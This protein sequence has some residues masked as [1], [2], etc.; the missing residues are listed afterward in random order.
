MQKQFSI[1]IVAIFVLM[2]FG[3]LPM[4]AQI[5]NVEEKRL[6]NK[7][8][9]MGSIDIEFNFTK[10]KREVIELENN[11]QL[12]YKSGRHLFL[13]LNEN[14]VIKDGDN[15]VLNNG[16][17]HLRYNY[18]LT[19]FVTAEVFSQYQFNQVQE[20][21]KRILVGAGPRLGLIA[22]DSIKVNLGLQIMKEWE[23]TDEYQ[24]NYRSSNYLSVFWQINQSIIFISTT[25]YQ[26]LLKNFDD[27]RI[28]NESG[29]LFAI[30]KRF[31]LEFTYEIL[32]DTDVPEG[33][34][35]TMY[36]INSG[37]VFSF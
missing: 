18:S 24:D 29:M 25:Y 22:K 1:K 17:Q 11:I 8:G 34:P 36:S 30:S 4:N 20:I 5:V 32:Y 9:L 31:S 26:P 10:N 16:Y 6:R 23:K 27:Y 2:L 28:S 7:D 19:D 35:E 14:E 15:D 3:S 13:F 21:D 33:V 12:S 37:I